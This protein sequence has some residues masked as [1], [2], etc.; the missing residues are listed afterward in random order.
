MEAAGHRWW[1]LVNPAYSYLSSNDPRVHIG[2]GAVSK[3]ESIRVLWPDGIAEIYEGVPANQHLV[4][5]K[6]TGKKADQ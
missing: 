1:R 3:V 5:R 4:L 2:L 6:G